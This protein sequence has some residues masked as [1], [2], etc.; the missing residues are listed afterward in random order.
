MY[1]AHALLQKIINEE[2]YTI[3]VQS[4]LSFFK[5]VENE[6]NKS[7][8]VQSKKRG[9]QRLPDDVLTYLQSIPTQKDEVEV[10]F[11]CI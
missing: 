8:S 7:L 2:F 6:D 4:V 3:V 10:Y 1:S 9:R 11:C 5:S